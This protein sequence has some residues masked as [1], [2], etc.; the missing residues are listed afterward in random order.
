MLRRE[1]RLQ[2]TRLR[3]Q[4][5]LRKHRHDVVRTVNVLGFLRL[6]LKV[7]TVTSRRTSSDNDPWS[8]HVLSTRHHPKPLTCVT[9]LNPHNR[10]MKEEGLLPVPI[11]Q[12]E[13]PGSERSRSVSEVT[14]LQSLGAQIGPNPGALSPAPLLLNNLLC[15]FLKY[16]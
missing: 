11:L 2:N 16:L 4:R 13:K 9:S 10:S 15:S 3:W 1:L 6:S 8:Q 12:M 7:M 14:Q 5:P